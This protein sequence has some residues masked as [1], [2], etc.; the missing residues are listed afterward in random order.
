M[1]AAELVARLRGGP[2]EREAA[3]T[4]LFQ[5]EA[6]HNRSASSSSSAAAR[7]EL[8]GLKLMA[9]RAR[10]LERELD[11]ASVGAAMDADEPK[12]ALTQ[13]LLAPVGPRSEE[14]E[15]SLADIAVACTAPL[16]EVLCKDVS[17]VDVAEWRR[18]V[19]VMAALSGVDPARMGGETLRTDRCNI[20]TAYLAPGSALGV[21]LAKDPAA[22]TI[23]DALTVSCAL[24]PPIVHM[25]ISTSLDAHLQV[26]GCA[27]I[28]EGLGHVLPGWF[29]INT[30]AGKKT[31]LFAPF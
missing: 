30:G 26:V 25:S 12:A 16:C 22:L 27:S 8:Q 14:E 6:E 23:E 9:L 3:Y 21:L 28:M 11:E 19:L 29:L 2:A 18:A 4:E 13:L 10:A 15:E 7:E 24:A 31:R 1:S 5:R 20:Y 17:E